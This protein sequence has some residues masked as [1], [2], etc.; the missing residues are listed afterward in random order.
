M[1]RC[2]LKAIIV[3]CV[4]LFS[5]ELV[6]GAC[7]LADRYIKRNNPQATIFAWQMCALKNNDDGAQMNL[8]DSYLNGKNGV[9]KDES[10]ALY[11]Y[12][13]A[14]ESGNAKAQLKLAQLLRSFDTSPERRA[15]LLEYQSKLTNLSKDNEGFQ[16]EIYH[17]YTLMLLASEKAE[18][19]WY[20]P[21]Q[22]RK[23]PE[24]ISK[25]LKNYQVNSKVQQAAL[26]DASRWK[27]RK[28]LEIAKEVVAE[29]EYADFEMK[30]KDPQ[31]R[32]K[33]IEELKKR[34][35]AYV[36]QKRKERM[37]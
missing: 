22:E 11:M 36:A 26:R 13:L 6:L 32:D 9:E 20:Y 2:F 28:L 37:G 7:P 8:A 12:H 21:S 15:K 25:E 17:P 5:S 19:K 3:F 29:A 34:Y 16:G 1:D 23:P 10:Q 33:T 35:D 30:L 27:T 14:A 31:K 18:N 24:E 4:G